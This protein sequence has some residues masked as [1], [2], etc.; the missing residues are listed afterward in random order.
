MR[1]MATAIIAVITSVLLLSA[2]GIYATMAFTV[3][4]RRREIGIRA[5]LGAD[6]RR[7]LAGIFGRAAAQLAAGVAVG[8]TLAAVLDWLGERTLSGGR[9]LRPLPPVVAGGGVGGGGAPG[10]AAAP[11]VAVPA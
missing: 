4:K 1:L 7:I 9:T 8:L 6:A 11:G 10:A 2:A 3:V 5:A